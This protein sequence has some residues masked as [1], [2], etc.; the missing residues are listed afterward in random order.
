MI[1]RPRHVPVHRDLRARHSLPA[2]QDFRVRSRRSCSSRRRFASS[3]SRRIRRRSRCTRSDHK[4][5]S[6]S[7]SNTHDPGSTNPP[8]PPMHAFPDASSTTSGCST[9]GPPL[10][11]RPHQMPPARVRALRDRVKR[12]GIRAEREP[13][14][15]HDHAQA[16]RR[17]RASTRSGRHRPSRERLPSP[18]GGTPLE[19]RGR[20][21][22]DEQAHQQSTCPPAYGPAVICTPHVDPTPLSIRRG[23]GT[24]RGTSRWRPS[25]Q[26]TS[27][28]GPAGPWPRTRTAGTSRS[29]GCSR[30]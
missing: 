23:F 6:A 28:P 24:R 10:I 7:R 13:H 26:P 3:A 25:P 19:A 21:A 12:R 9:S 20:P 11:P 8:S 14:P 18:A 16:A 30:R 27:S 17:T 5:C 2:L 15:M 4:S 29:A 1:L 22:A